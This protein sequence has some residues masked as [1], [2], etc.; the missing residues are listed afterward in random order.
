VA[1]VYVNASRIVARFRC[2]RRSFR[3]HADP[4]RPRPLDREAA[5]GWGEGSGGVAWR[6]DTAASGRENASRSIRHSLPRLPACKML[7]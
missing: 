2:G 4:P 1:A 3:R 7:E 6:E 5:R